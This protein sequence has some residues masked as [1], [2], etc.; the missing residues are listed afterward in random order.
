M[1]FTG[2]EHDSESGLDH[3][4]HRKYGSLMGRWTSPDLLPGDISDPQSLNR[5]CYSHNNPV[6]LTDL[7]GLQDSFCV[8]M[9]DPDRADCICNRL[10]DVNDLTLPAN[11]SDLSAAA[12][13]LPQPSS[14]A[15]DLQPGS[16]TDLTTLQGAGVGPGSDSTGPSTLGTIQTGLDILG[17][18]P[19]VGDFANAASGVI[20]LAQGHYGAAALSF[21]SAIPLIGTAGEV[22]KI[23]KLG[24]EGVQGFKTFRAFK[25]FYGAAEEG[26]QWHHV[27]EQGGGRVARFGPEAIHNIENLVQVPTEIHSQ[28]SG[29]YSSVQKGLSE[30]KTVRQWLKTK[31]FEEQYQFGREVMRR[32]GL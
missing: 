13:L 27:V 14:S 3:F 32:F 1:H 12:Q 28:I 5:Y 24:E 11:S 2:E 17:V 15:G 29:F 4:D 6:N 19:V 16:V 18:V 30:G 21:A 26:L 31:S 20:S 25:K 7:L 8:C 9:G 10:R 22:L 23:A